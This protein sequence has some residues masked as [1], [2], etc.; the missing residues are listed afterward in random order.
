MGNVHKPQHSHGEYLNSDYS[1]DVDESILDETGVPFS[2]CQHRDEGTTAHFDRY[3][4]G[5]R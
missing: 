2:A 4:A 3:V 5:D 1:S